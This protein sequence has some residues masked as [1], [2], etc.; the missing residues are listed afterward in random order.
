[1]MVAC[2]TQLTRLET[3]TIIVLMMRSIPS[4]AE[5][6]IT[7]KTMGDWMTVSILSF[8]PQT[9]WLEMK[10][11]AIISRILIHPMAM[12]VTISMKR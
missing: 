3:G 10:E 11:P 2:Q 12:M 9:S 5:D 1:M 8:L 7:A 4:P 6:I